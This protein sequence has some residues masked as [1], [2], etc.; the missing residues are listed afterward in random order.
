MS[1]TR[2]H[3]ATLQIRRDSSVP[4]PEMAASASMASTFISSSLAGRYVDKLHNASAHFSMLA[5]ES[6]QETRSA[7]GIT[8]HLSTRVSA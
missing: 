2:L 6:E 3:S 7:T 4:V 5:Q 8:G 1:L